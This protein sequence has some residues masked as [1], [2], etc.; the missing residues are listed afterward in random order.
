MTGQ[1][2]DGFGEHSLS[3]V[4]RAISIKIIRQCGY[5]R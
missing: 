1:T 2:D 5:S 3:G 4:N